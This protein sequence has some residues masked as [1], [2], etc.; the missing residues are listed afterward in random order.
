MNT[1]IINIPP[2]GRLGDK[3]ISVISFLVVCKYLNLKPNILT[4]F[5]NIEGDW[6]FY[7]PRLL[8]FNENEFIFDKNYRNSKYI[9]LHLF[10]PIKI[11]DYLVRIYPNLTFEELSNNYMILAKQVVKPSFLILNKIPSGLENTYGIHLRK[12]DRVNDNDDKRLSTLNSELPIIIDNLL[13]D[14]KN[15]INTEPNPKF[16]IISED[17][18]WK[19]HITDLVQNYANENNKKIYIYKID[20]TNEYNLNNYEAVLDFFCLSKCKEILMGVKSTMFS[21]AA[22]MLGNNKLR[23]YFTYDTENYKDCIVH[24]YSSVIKINNKNNYDINYHRHVTNWIDNVHVSELNDK[25]PR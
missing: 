1:A 8:D 2:H 14:V 3:L 19:T 15:I 16:L 21:Y 11:Y 23:N 17:N 4:F 7:D 5:T 25:N 6:D 13:L 10:Y 12:S 24:A 20:Y 18:D 22:A 9:F